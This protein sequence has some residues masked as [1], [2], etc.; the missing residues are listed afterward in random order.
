MEDRGYDASD[1]VVSEYINA[2]MSADIEYFI[3]IVRYC[4]ELQLIIEYKAYS[5]G[6][7]DGAER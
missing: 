3:Q 7:L 4:Y 2:R 5:Y 6:L 1:H